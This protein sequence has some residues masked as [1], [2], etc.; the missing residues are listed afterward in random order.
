MGLDIKLAITES[1]PRAQGERT[2]SPRPGFATAYGF[3]TIELMVVLVI[4]GITLAAT[5]PSF[6]NSLKTQRLDGAADRIAVKMR[7]ARSRAIAENTPYLIAWYAVSG[8]LF[9]VRDENGDGTPNWGD[10]YQEGP[11]GLPDGVSLA[12]STTDPFPED[13]VSF[14]PDGSTSASGTLVLSNEKGLKLNINLL[15]PSGVVSVST[16]NS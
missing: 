10:E 3:S 8:E 6:R 11:I 16:P 2:G 12:N 15:Q 5:I 7:L 4:L 9:L 14:L 13:Y 1:F